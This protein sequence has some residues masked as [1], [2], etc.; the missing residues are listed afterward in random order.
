MKIC[1][2]DDE[3]IY[4]HDIFLLQNGLH[5][6]PHEK[7]PSVSRPVTAGNISR[8]KRAR[9]TSSN[10]LLRYF[11]ARMMVD[12]SPCRRFEHTRSQADY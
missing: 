11:Y 3:N 9:S 6:N 2:D 5:L 7:Y 4:P 10:E 12:I 1:I 8:P